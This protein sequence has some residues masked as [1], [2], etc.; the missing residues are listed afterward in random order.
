MV[1]MNAFDNHNMVLPNHPLPVGNYSR[2]EEFV[3][4]FNHNMK[5]VIYEA[6][7]IFLAT[8]FPHP[9]FYGGSSSNAP[10]GVD[11]GINMEPN[12]NPFEQRRMVNVNAFDNHNMVLPDHPSPFGNYSRVEG[13]VPGFNHNMA[14]PSHPNP[15][16][17]GNEHPNDG[18]PPQPRSD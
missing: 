18:N 5:Q 9:G 16:E 7:K 10:F 4:G 11:G 17:S 6:F 1:N 14:L 12:L 8:P 3:P 2:V 15:N 13:F